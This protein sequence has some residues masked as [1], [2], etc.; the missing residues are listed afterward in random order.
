MD[1]NFN[2]FPITA[3]CTGKITGEKPASSFCFS[4]HPLDSLLGPQDGFALL[5]CSG[6]SGGTEPSG[7]KPNLVHTSPARA[8]KSRSQISLIREREQ[9]QS[10]DWSRNRVKVH[11]KTKIRSGV[12]MHA[13]DLSTWEVMEVGSS[14]Q[15]LLSDRAIQAPISKK[16]KKKNE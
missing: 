12:M 16:K 13:Y 2:T 10:L 14:V 4:K 11:S 7:L 5:P 3:V 15:D 8:Q 1:L 9:G 6:R